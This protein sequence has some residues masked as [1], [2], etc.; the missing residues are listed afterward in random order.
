MPI[1]VGNPVRRTDK[2]LGDHNVPID[3]ARRRR[4]VHDMLRRM[5]TPVLIKHRYN[6]L[7]FQKNKALRSPVFDDIYAQT[8][9]HDPLSHGVGY[10]GPE[11]ADNEWYDPNGDGEIVVSKTAP[12]NGWLKAPYYRGFGQGTL[13]YIIEPDRSEDFYKASIGGPLFKIQTAMAIAPWFPDINDNDLIIQVQLDGQG[14][15][16]DSFERFEAKSVNQVSM[17]GRD[18]SGRKERGEAFGNS[19]MMNQ[20]FEMA[21][22]P[23]ND[24]LYSVETDR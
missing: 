16:V 12:Q 2:Y 13:T 6:D 10:V 4:S 19:H 18:S 15:V 3:I 17:R 23:M 11:L 9:N 14:N 8:R 21:L 24:V 5:G 22:I 20:T 1:R 7:D